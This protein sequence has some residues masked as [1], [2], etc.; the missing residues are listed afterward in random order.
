MENQNKT[1]VMI[2]G[3]MM[4]EIFRVL[5][6]R[7]AEQAETSLTIDQF[8]LLYSISKEKE[9]VIQKQMAEIMGKDKSA[10]LRMIDCL[11]SRDLVRRVVDP[12]DRRK[13]NLM[14]SKKGER[15]IE[16]WLNIERELNKELL[17]GLEQSDIDAFFRVIDY[18]RNKA[19]D[20]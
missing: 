15:T 4:K 12:N 19:K 11:E 10:I 7:T 5:K 9:E 13:N 6:K 1:L 2:V 18:M 20:L 17:D 3:G 14:V 8:G 16:Q